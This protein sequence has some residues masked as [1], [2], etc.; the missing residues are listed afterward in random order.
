MIVGLPL[1]HLV[2]ERGLRA[3]IAHE[4]GHYAGGD[5]KLGPWIHRTRA[6]I[7]RTIAAAQR[8]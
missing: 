8:R 1:L 2:S 4:F 3:V 6:A 7:G 5:T